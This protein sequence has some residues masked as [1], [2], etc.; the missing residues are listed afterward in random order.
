MFVPDRVEFSMRFGNYQLRS[1]YGGVRAFDL[2]HALQVFHVVDNIKRE[3][4]EDD[5]EYLARVWRIHPYHVH[6]IIEQIC[7]SKY[8]HTIK[9]EFRPEEPDDE[10]DAEEI[11]EEIR[12]AR[13]GRPPLVL[14]AQ[15][16]WHKQGPF[17]FD[18]LSGGERGIIFISGAM[19]LAEYCSRYRGALLVLDLGSNFDDKLLSDY[20]ER[21]QHRDFR[22]QT[23]LIS[24]SLRP[25][26]NWTGWS[27]AR[28][29]GTRPNAYF[30]QTM[31]A[32]EQTDDIKTQC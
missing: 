12:K 1:E 5:L 21:L 4:F 31:I 20:A 3:P 11:P 7:S 27:I 29:M 2:S 9:A 8:G 28:L 14:W 16:T 25:K 6:G 15:F 26:V 30:D 18:G 24:P 22:F 10:E 23:I 19:L 13:H 17:A 32:D